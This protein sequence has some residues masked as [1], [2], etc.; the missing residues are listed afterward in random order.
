MTRY[1]SSS[2]DLSRPYRQQR[3]LSYQ[4]GARPLLASTLPPLGCRPP[5]S[6]YQPAR[7]HNV[8]G[9][10][11]LNLTKS[12]PRLIIIGTS[13]S[14]FCSLNGRDTIRLCFF[15]IA[16]SLITILLDFV[17]F[18]TSIPLNSLGLL[19]IT[20]RYVGMSDTTSTWCVSVLIRR[21]EIC[22]E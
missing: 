4:A 22:S 12:S 19:L 21:V 8:S 20:S 6:I 5:V 9:G 16:P 13:L 3:L 11:G 14:K 15:H 2:G 17:K 1:I 7:R 10:D 18:S